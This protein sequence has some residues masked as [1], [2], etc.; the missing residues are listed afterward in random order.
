MIT[1][2]YFASLRET[3]GKSIDQ[4]ETVPG[5]SVALLLQRV[6]AS[7]SPGL[8]GQDIRAAINHEMVENSALVHDG[9]E[10]AFFPPVTGG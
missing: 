6:I 7:T 9:D 4:L 1:V 8:S 2:R 5:E 10:V 3:L